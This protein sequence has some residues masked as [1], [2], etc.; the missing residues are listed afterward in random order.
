MDGCAILFKKSRFVLVEKHAL[1]FNHVAMS[2][3]RS[4]SFPLAPSLPPSHLSF[5]HAAHRV[6]GRSCGLLVLLAF[7]VAISRARSVACA[8]R[9]LCASRKSSLEFSRVVYFLG[10]RTLSW[11]LG[12]WVFRLS[13]VVGCVGSE[14]RGVPEARYCMCLRPCLPGRRGCGEKNP[15][16]F[17]F[18][19]IPVFTTPTP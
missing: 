4:D 19:F 17:L 2:R 13:C 10:R 3:A 18:L 5:S 9:C 1:E 8:L 14:Q 7:H 11:L 6:P 16:A 15:F 12:A